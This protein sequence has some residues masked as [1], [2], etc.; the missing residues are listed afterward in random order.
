MTA[1]DLLG[2]PV[3]PDADEGWREAGDGAVTARVVLMAETALAWKVFDGATIAW[4]PKSECGL[5]LED[6]KRGTAR[7]PEWLAR[8]KDLL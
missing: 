2:D 1:R 8:E 4:L 7:V 3:A 5:D 6:G